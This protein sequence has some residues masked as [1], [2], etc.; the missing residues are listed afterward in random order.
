MNP[1]IITRIKT[2]D[3]RNVLIN[4]LDV[5]YRRM[6]FIIHVEGIICEGIRVASTAGLTFRMTRTSSNN[7]INPIKTSKIMLNDEGNPAKYDTIGF[8]LTP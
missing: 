4:E 6:F 5:G 3:R 7:T 2:I 8:A 1:K